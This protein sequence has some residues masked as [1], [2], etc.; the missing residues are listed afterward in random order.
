M[1]QGERT[2]SDSPVHVH[3][4][5]A[6]WSTVNAE[7]G[8]PG[9]LTPLTWSFYGYGCRTGMT[10][11]WKDLG[12]LPAS[13]PVQTADVDSWFVGAFFGR[14]TM[15]VDLYARM[16]DRMPGT[17]GAALEE[18]FFGVARAGASTSTARRYPIVAVKAPAAI[19]RARHTTLREFPRIVQWRR[20]AV[21]GALT[22][23]LADARTLLLKAHRRLGPALQR[24]ILLTMIA[25]NF[26]EQVTRLCAAAGQPG[27]ELDLTISRSGTDEFRIVED[28]WSV[29][30]GSRPL[31]AFLDQHGY[32]GPNEGHLDGVVWRENPAPVQDLLSR[33]SDL[34]EESTPERIARR[35]AEQSARARQTLLAALPRATRPAALA[36]LRM[37]SAMP[38]LRELGKSMFLQIADV[39]RAASRTLGTHL[40]DVNQLA[41]PSDVFFLTVDEVTRP[42][43]QDWT[44][45]AL[46]RRSD[47]AYFRS[48]EL[49]ESWRGNPAPVTPTADGLGDARLSE[50]TGLG[51]SGGVIEGIARVVDDP[52]D[53]DFEPGAVLVCHLTDPSWSAIMALAG[54][55]VI[56][57]GSAISH[58]AIIARELGIPC[59]INARVA[60]SQ[61]RDGDRVLVDG[62]A[63]TVRLLR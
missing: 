61:L 22:A 25:Q 54:A 17:S 14:A 24:H 45:L 2:L 13:T 3:S 50:L 16:A 44:S 46:E 36:L 4:L 47:D 12:A 31:S 32:H 1:Q 15:N 29:A 8:F 7:E 35:R 11:L 9:V 23:D 38:V 18:H 56:N 41:E 60:T 62:T 26:F 42:S 55:L 63:G 19:L 43:A 57:V 39:G 30:Q 49:P 33:F 51:V 21:A 34:A 6:R 58:G 5:G 40:A 59:V 20:E 48:I 53:C 27:L 52:T 37:A 10:Q 28:L